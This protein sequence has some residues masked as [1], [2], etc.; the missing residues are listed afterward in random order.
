MRAVLRF[1]WLALL[2]MVLASEAYAQPRG[3]S[4][5]QLNFARE[6]Y[7]R[8]T[9]H[10]EL[11]DY[12][13]AIEEY[14]R[15]Y[16]ISAAPALLF[17]L[18]QVYRLK[19]D[20]A[21]AL[22]FYTNYLRLQPGAPNRADVEGLIVEMRAAVEKQ[23]NE[24]AA[25]NQPPP[26]RPQPPSPPPPPPPAVIVPPTTT[27]TVTV[28][29]T[30]TT[31]HPAPQ[32]QRWRA[33]AWTAGTLGIVGL[34]ATIA[35]IAVGVRANSDAS[36]I[37]HAAAMNNQAWTM[38]RQDQ[39]HDGQRAAAAATALDIIGPVLIAGGAVVAVLA[40]RDHR[41]GRRFALVP[42]G[43]GVACAF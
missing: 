3:A 41:R 36:D 1:G 14:K 21:T 18:G 19:K 20:P 12:D 38:A 7:Q 11:G 39:Y 25:K 35:G 34:G 13:R 37:Q 42:S 23:D 22:R 15:A 29:P 28:T 4:P 2:A 33:E 8:A 5:Q 26:P 32:G 6:L 40:W 31:S 10:Y 43:N 17:N 24:R 27:P 30:V 9:R 16:E